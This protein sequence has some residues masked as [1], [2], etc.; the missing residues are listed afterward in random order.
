MNLQILYI[1]LYVSSLLAVFIYTLYELF[2]VV[3]EKDNA[4]ETKAPFA[5][6]LTRTVHIPIGILAIGIGVFA[7]CVSAAIGCYLNSSD[8]QMLT[9]GFMAG[10][11][12]PFFFVGVPLGIYWMKQSKKSPASRTNE[13]GKN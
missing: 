4:E 12:N 8:P 13:R 6:F 10:V 3:K 5:P 7:F 11:L 9:M 1:E 2:N